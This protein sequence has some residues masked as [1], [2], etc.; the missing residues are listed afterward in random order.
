MPAA[1]GSTSTTR[2][3]AGST[4][5]GEGYSPRGARSR[6]SGVQVEEATGSA[7]RRPDACLGVGEQL[8]DVIPIME[9]PLLEQIG[10]RQHA[11]TRVHRMTDELVR[12]EGP[13]HGNPRFA[14]RP[15]LAD[16]GRH[17]PFSI[18]PGGRDGNLI[19]VWLGHAV[20]CPT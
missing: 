19:P 9:D 6:A 12:T 20:G 1:I 13:D 8:A 4:D 17:R 15:E 5:R 18:S 10:D 7:H 14:T 11:R 2:T 16:H 3:T